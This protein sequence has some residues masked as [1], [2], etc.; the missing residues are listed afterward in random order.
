[1]RVVVREVHTDD[2]RAIYLNNENIYEGHYVSIQDVCDG[3]QELIDN[4][5]TIDSIKGEYYYL[6]EEYAEEHG[7]PNKFS[8]FPKNVLE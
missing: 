2:W 7:F 8:N 3:L 1:M 4:G 6:N 5:N